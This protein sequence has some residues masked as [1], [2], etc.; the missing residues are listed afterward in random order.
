[1]L[2]LE[3]LRTLVCVVDEGSFTRAAGRVH[4]TQSTVSQ[5][6]RKLEQMVG[7]T[8]LLRDRTGNQV[9]ATEDGELMLTYARKLLAMADEAELV[10]SAPRGAQVIRLGVPEDFDV[11][12]LTALLAGFAASHPEIRL[13]TGSGM[14]TDL[15]ARLAAGDLDLA[16]IK[17]EPGDGPCLAAWPERLAW[18]GDKRLLLGRE[19]VPLVLFPQGCIYRKRMIYAL[20][21]AGRPWRAAYHSQSLA[22][23]QA[24]VA[25]GL[26]VSLLPAF[27]CLPEHGVLGPAQG[28]AQA[29]HTELAIVGNAK[30]ALGAQ[31]DL[32]AVLKQAVGAEAAP[33]PRRMAS[34]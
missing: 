19:P 4:R 28:L 34:A 18:V 32:V 25:A 9:T 27:A 22:G 1:M 12:R 11:S 5:Q 29:P 13:E 24:A 7:K 31:A 33:P 30:A 8:L 6:V 2:D 3:L 15:K 26:G 14:S 23:V 10:L 17:R 20:E 21:S 16:L